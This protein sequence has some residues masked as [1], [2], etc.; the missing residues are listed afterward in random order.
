MRTF[1]EQA[2]FNK[3]SFINFFN[4]RESFNLQLNNNYAYGNKCH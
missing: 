2:I 3:R 1:N 4:G